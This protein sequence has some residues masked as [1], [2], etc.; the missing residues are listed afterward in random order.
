MLKYFSIQ[1]YLLVVGRSIPS[2]QCRREGVGVTSP[3]ELVYQY[4][5]EKTVVHY[6]AKKIYITGNVLMQRKILISAWLPLGF[7]KY[8]FLI[9]KT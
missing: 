7:R 1:F 8:F 5:F 2:P 4:Y 9:I 3:N 6:H